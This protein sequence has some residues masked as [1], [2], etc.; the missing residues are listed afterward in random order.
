MM[1]Y[2]SNPNNIDSIKGSTRGAADST[3]VKGLNGVYVDR[4]GFRVS[5]KDNGVWGTYG[6]FDSKYTAAYVFSIVY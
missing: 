3:W 5:I 2:Y 6:Y 1:M 4:K